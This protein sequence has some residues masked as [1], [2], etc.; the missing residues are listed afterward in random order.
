MFAFWRVR[1]GK[2]VKERAKATSLTYILQLKALI[3]YMEVSSL[4]ASN[5]DQT[6]GTFNSEVT[7]GKQMEVELLSLQRCTYLILEYEM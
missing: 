3:C 6:E 4:F 1:K 5:C 2:W 7:W